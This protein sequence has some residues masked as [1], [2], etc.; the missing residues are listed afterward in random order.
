MHIYLRLIAL[1]AL[2]A[3]GSALAA[4]AAPKPKDKVFVIKRGPTDRDPFIAPMMEP[5]KDE[6]KPR[7]REQVPQDPPLPPRPDLEKGLIQAQ[8]SFARGEFKAAAQEARA[9]LAQLAED[10]GRLPAD[11]AD[12]QRA[13]TVRSCLERLEK[14]ADASLAFLQIE[15]A[16]EV[17]GIIWCERPSGR[18]AIVGDRRLKQ[19][20]PIDGGF[21]SS[22]NPRSLIVCLRG[23]SFVLAMK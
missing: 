14:R 5:Q 8:E 22:I 18:A 16:S 15:Q 1:A 11:H 17:R 12:V 7:G 10:V 6:E 2:C 3:F 13:V 21:V 23:Y 9:A 19:G 20:D 4:D